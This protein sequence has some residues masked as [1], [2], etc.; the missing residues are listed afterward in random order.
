MWPKQVHRSLLL[1]KIGVI[2]I[3]FTKHYQEILTRI[4]IVIGQKKDARK[5]LNSDL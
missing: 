3:R 4:N 1:N 5:P 2:T